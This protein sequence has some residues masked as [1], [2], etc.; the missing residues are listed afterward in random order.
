M[1]SLF[2][3]QD[4]SAVQKDEDADD[5]SSENAVLHRSLCFPPGDFFVI[6]FV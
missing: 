4:F 5:E 6:D 1:D 2:D 3:S